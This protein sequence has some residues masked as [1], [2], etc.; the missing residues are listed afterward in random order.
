MLAVAVP[1]ARGQDEW[2][3]A[4]AFRRPAQSRDESKGM[5]G[6][7]SGFTPSDAA[8]TLV[9]EPGSVVHF[10]GLVPD[11]LASPPPFRVLVGEAL[12]LSGTLQSV[13]PTV[14]SMWE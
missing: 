1:G 11:S 4:G 8:A 5:R 9:L 13:S 14:G 10:Q 12:R 6:P 7:A 2:G 3:I